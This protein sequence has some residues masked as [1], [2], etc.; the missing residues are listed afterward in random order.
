MREVFVEQIAVLVLLHARVEQGRT[1]H[2]AKPPDPLLHEV[3]MLIPIVELLLQRG[4]VVGLVR[5]EQFGK[6][7][8]GKV[9]WCGF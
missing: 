6:P 4:H 7:N 1:V 3:E 8:R 9:E 2:Q 5:S